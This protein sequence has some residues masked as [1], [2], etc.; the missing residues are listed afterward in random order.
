MTVYC[1]NKKFDI[2]N[3][4]KEYEVWLKAQYTKQIKIIQSDQGGEYFSNEFTN[5]KEKSTMQSLTVHDV[6]EENGVAEWLN[7]MLLEHAYAMLTTA[8]LPKNLWPKRI[9]HTLWLKDRRFT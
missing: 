8:E 9:H 3:R 4:Y 5:H 2:F 6:P 1:I 7:Q